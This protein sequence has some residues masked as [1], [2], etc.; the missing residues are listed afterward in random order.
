MVIITGPDNKQCVTQP[1][2]DPNILQRG[3]ELYS[4]NT[5]VSQRHTVINQAK[6]HF[7]LCLIMKP[8]IA[9][10]NPVITTQV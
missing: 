2:L 4:E 7:E 5:E 6:K 1:C 9:I 10:A 8:R 3:A